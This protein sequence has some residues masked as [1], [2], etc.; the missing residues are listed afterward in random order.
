VAAIQNTGPYTD[1]IIPRELWPTA[2]E[3]AAGAAANFCVAREESES[4]A[5]AYRVAAHRLS[6]SSE[7]ATSDALVSAHRELAVDHDNHAA[8]REAVAK[9]AKQIAERGYEL[10]DRLKAIDFQAHQQIAASPPAAREA[11]ID[12]ARARAVAVHAEFAV[13]VAGHH[14][15]ATEAVAPLVAGIVGRGAPAA[16]PPAAPAPADWE[17]DDPGPGGAGQRAQKTSRETGDASS[18]EPGGEEQRRKKSI[19]EV[20]SART[21]HADGEELRQPIDA[22]VGSLPDGLS[23]AGGL[24]GGALSSAGGLGLSPMSSAGGGFGGLGSANGLSGMPTG[25]GTQSAGLSGVP[26]GGSVTAV[27]TGQ[28]GSAATGFG[29]GVSAGSTAGSALSLPAP[30]SVGTPTSGIGATPPAAG[31]SVSSASTPAGFAASGATAAPSSGSGSL[32]VSSAAPAPMMVPSP[33]MGAPVAAGVGSLMASPVGGSTAASGPVGSSAASPSLTASNGALLVPASVVG[34]GGT[35]SRER[36]ESAELAAAK[37]LAL[38]LRRDCDGARY[39]CIEWAVGI[40]RSEANGGS[41][42]VVTSNEGFGYIPWGVFPPRS[43]RLMGTDKLAYNG[44]RQHW[45]GCEDPAEVMVEYAKLRAERGSR[46]V[47]LGVTRDS[48][49]GRIPGVE[50]GVCPP[51]NLNEVYG[52]PV[53]DDMHTH[54]LEVLYPDLYARLQRLTATEDATRAFANQACVP[55]AMQMID[56]VRMAAG[57]QGPPELR[58]MWDALGTGDAISDDEWQQYLMASMVF[59]VNL[60]ASR[61]PLDAGVAERER[62]HAEWVAARAM[63]FLRGWQRNPADVADMIYAAAMAYPGDFAVKFEPLLRVVEDS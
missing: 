6:E 14:G 13:A 16:P 21:P 47:A 24:G 40:F 3:A 26:G 44:F 12:E 42:C 31:L 36:T 34:S 15:K 25:V 32:G 4:A 33:G 23:P 52:E 2:H 38:K 7:G 17:A 58:Q 54:R 9:S 55:L 11:I 27:Q 10:I 45:F 37:A 59:N 20:A 60:S 48:A 62:Y 43:A 1:E 56:A 46:F 35:S 53:L 22:A 61:L 49:Q 39:P 28:I 50:Y 30:T 41:E 19:G 5:D 63:E 57:V 51:R 29:Q 18:V 8:I